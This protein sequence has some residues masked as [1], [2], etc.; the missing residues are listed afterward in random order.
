M[1]AVAGF[2]GLV[3]FGSPRGSLVEGDRIVPLWASLSGR[4]RMMALGVY[5][6]VDYVVEKAALEGGEVTLRPAYRL[7]P[8]LEREWPVTVPLSS[9]DLVVSS[10]VHLALTAAGSMA[11]ALAPLLAALTLRQAVSLYVIPTASMEP[12][13][14]VS[15][16]IVVEKVTR[17]HIAPRDGEVVFFKPP[18]R[19]LELIA[20]AGGVP[21][22]E[23][24]LLVKRVVCSSTGGEGLQTDER[25]AGL[26]RGMLWVEGD[27]AA[28]STDSRAFGGLSLDQVVG[29]PLLRVLPFRRAGL[30]RS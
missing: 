16:V 24:A 14:Q 1:M 18:P 7:V 3:A 12:T 30:V 26:P 23:D 9:I 29:R 6:G 25:C 10:P 5:P 19:L 11:L 27:N 13:M 21:L 15:D 2:M 22:R 17:G 28:H 20:D 8:K 4:S